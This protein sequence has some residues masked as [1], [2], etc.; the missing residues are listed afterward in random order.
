MSSGLGP[1]SCS[2][3]SVGSSPRT[4]EWLVIVLSVR[5][6]PSQRTLAVNPTRLE[7]GLSLD[8]PFSSP[9]RSRSTPLSETE[10][11]IRTPRL[12]FGLQTPPSSADIHV[13]GHGARARAG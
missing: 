9:I 6:P 11:V 5:K 7:S 2:A 10:S 3:Y 13:S 8:W 12:W 4:I 1:L